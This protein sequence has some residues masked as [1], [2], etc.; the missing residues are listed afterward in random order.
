MKTRILRIEDE[1]MAGYRWS[2]SFWLA[3]SRGGSLTLSLRQS[4]RGNERV[5]IEPASGLRDGVAVYEAL[6]GMLVELGCEA[7][8]TALE[9]VAAELERF[10]ATL[11]AEFRNASSV[12][13]Q[14]DEDKRR[15]AEAGIQQ[16][17]TPYRP[18]IEAYV[19]RFSDEKLYYPGS[20][21]VYPSRRFWVRRF[22]EQY[23]LA[24]GKLPTGEHWIKV[25]GY[26]GPSHDFS[27]LADVGR[28]EGASVT[29]THT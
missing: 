24:H 12:L 28:G 8:S 19:T 20:G 5:R 21:Y 9:P 29:A 22:L 6:V 11:A 10:G 4:A 3:R 1:N 15:A 17:L 23:V 26:S 18:A 14:R 13:E 2:Y 16:T 7:V 27:D 25:P